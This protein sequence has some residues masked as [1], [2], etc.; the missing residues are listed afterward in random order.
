MNL[1]I[2]GGLSAGQLT[3]NSIEINGVDVEL[4]DSITFAALSNGTGTISGS[5]QLTTEF[6]SRYINSNGDGVI[7][8]SSQVDATSVTNFD[9]NVQ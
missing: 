6:D 3:D 1:L 9:T 4:G 8:G 7:S 5:A 2:I